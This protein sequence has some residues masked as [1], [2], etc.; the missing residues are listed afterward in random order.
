MYLT[1]AIN[2]FMLALCLIATSYALPADKQEKASIIAD[3]SNYNYKT[4]IDV[5]EGNVQ[6]DQGSTHIRADKVITERN[7]LH[8][9]KKATA[10]GIHKLAHYWTTPKEGEMEVNASA[11]IIKFYPI[12]SNVTLVTN[13]EIRQ[14]DN[15]FHGE[16]IHY[17]KLAQ[18]ITV[19]SSE[20]ARAVIVYNPES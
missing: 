8:K 16:L 17:N 1:K 2:F 4:G 11:K 15:T 12:E 5:Y 18:T 13:V 20:H 9:I 7:Q 3:S 10:Y 6:I 14:G 19:P